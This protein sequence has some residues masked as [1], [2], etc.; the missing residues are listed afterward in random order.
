MTLWQSISRHQPPNALLLISLL[1]IG[2]AAQ[3]K[4]HSS[5]FHIKVSAV[6]QDPL[7]I[8]VS[9]SCAGRMNATSADAAG[10]GSAW[11]QLKAGIL[12]W[13]SPS[14]IPSTEENHT[15]L[16]LGWRLVG[17]VGGGEWNRGKRLK[18]SI[19]YCLCPWDGRNNIGSSA[20]YLECG[21]SPCSSLRRLEGCGEEHRTM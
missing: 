6:I 15:I 20:A 13:I 2:M 16:T 11:G 21:R 3:H 14:H 9:V 10:M 19:L 12:A 7:N 1:G 8:L 5:V 18:I 4:K 17:G